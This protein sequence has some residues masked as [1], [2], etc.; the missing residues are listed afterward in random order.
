MFN[1]FLS[2][3]FVIIY[4]TLHSFVYLH[5]HNLVYPMS[6][7]SYAKFLLCGIHKHPVHPRMILFSYS[8][9]Y[10]SLA[11]DYKLPT[12]RPVSQFCCIF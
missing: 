7:I 10:V 4:S 9:F 8:Y 6:Y 12:I 5:I 11:I 3:F 1:L 2:Y